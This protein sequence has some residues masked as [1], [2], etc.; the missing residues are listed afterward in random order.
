MAFDIDTELDSLETA[1]FNIDA[2][3]DNIQPA[4]FNIDAELDSFDAPKA[5]AFDINAELGA[6]RIR[7]RHL[8]I[9]RLKSY[10]SKI[11]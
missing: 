3:L 2:E 11:Q 5:K 7:N 4:E 6:L 8:K 10:S 1:P 9:Q